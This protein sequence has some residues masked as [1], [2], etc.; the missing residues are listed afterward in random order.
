MSH[1]LLQVWFFEFAFKARFSFF[2]NSGVVSFATAFIFFTV[3][4]HSVTVLHKNRTFRKFFNFVHHE[5]W[6]KVFGW[7]IIC[8]GIIH[9]I[10]WNV[11]IYMFTDKNKWSVQEY[12]EM[13]D[14]DGIKSTDD[15]P[16]FFEF[17]FL[18]L[19]GLTGL[20]SLDKWALFFWSQTRGKTIQIPTHQESLIKMCFIHGF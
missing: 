14:D 11:T 8:H 4:Y 10:G 6:H 17:M 18:T 19:P 15:V 2:E 7:L 1:V 9:S 12:R 3:S 16:G 5:K 20:C 13:L